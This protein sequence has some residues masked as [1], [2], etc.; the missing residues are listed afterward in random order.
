MMSDRETA[1]DTSVR[2]AT[3][4]GVARELG[5]AHLVS[6]PRAHGWQIY[7]HGD[8]D[9]NRALRLKPDNRDKLNY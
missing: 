3:Q 5:T 7:H 1:S 2:E 8:V 9:R 6:R 4:Q